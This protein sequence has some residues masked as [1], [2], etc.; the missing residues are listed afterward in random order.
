M[1]IEVVMA[2]Y[3]ESECIEAAIIGLASAAG[4]VIREH[5]IV[6]GP[7]TGGSSK[8]T[9]KGLKQFVANLP[10]LGWQVRSRR[11]RPPQVVTRSLFP[12]S[13]A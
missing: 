10:R 12:A 11:R 7:R 9:A 4:F 6:F 13:V 3:N 8:L 5:P 2:T 1:R